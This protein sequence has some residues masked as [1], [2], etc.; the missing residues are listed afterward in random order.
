MLSHTVDSLPPY[1]YPGSTQLT[2]HDREIKARS[3]GILRYVAANNLER[4]IAIDDLDLAPFIAESYFHQ[5]DSYTGLT[6]N[7][8]EICV[9]KLSG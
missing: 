7:G 8:M 6:D 2:C 9:R 5:T 1:D 3:A 4:W